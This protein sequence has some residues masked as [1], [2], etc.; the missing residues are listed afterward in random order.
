MTFWT[1]SYGVQFRYLGGAPEVGSKV[2]YV[3]ARSDQ[4]MPTHFWPGGPTK[5]KSKKQGMSWRPFP[6]LLPP[7]E[8]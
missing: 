7:A 4:A 2:C 5:S 8:L 1:Y 3:L 6:V